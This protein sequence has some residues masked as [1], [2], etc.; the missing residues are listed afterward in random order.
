MS[1]ARDENNLTAF[2]RIDWVKIGVLVKRDAQDCK[3]HYQHYNE[4][5]ASVG[6]KTGPFSPDEVCIQCVLVMMFHSCVV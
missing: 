1:S 6:L 2:D 5:A 3:T 4:K